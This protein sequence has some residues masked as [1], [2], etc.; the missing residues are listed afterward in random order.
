M[1][2]TTADAYLN[3]LMLEC[4]NVPDSLLLVQRYWLQPL[5]VWERDQ[6][7]PIQ[8]TCCQSQVFHD[9]VG[10]SLRSSHSWIESDSSLSHVTE[11][12]T[13]DFLT[14]HLFSFSLSGFPG[15]TSCP[16]TGAPTRVSSPTSV[17]CVRRSL[18]VVTTCQNTSKS[19]GFP[20]AAGQSVQQTDAPRG[21]LGSLG[22]PRSLL[23]RQRPRELG[24]SAQMFAPSLSQF[25]YE[26]KHTLLLLQRSVIVLI[27][28]TKVNRHSYHP[29]IS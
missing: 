29:V 7:I 1:F 24:V 10:S 3:V 13:S 11:V 19:T 25:E 8:K 15:R 2:I 21:T 27:Y 22:M 18:P 5:W 17:Q 26:R 12:H 23:R 28:C 14:K 9:S 16:D 6:V 20:G 4:H